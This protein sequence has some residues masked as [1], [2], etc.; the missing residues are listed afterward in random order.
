MY[1]FDQRAGSVR[2]MPFAL[3]KS[4]RIERQRFG[5]FRTMLALAQLINMPIS[6]SRSM[7]AS[8]SLLSLSFKALFSSFSASCFLAI[9]ASS[10]SNS[11][12][13]FLREVH[14]TKSPVLR[15]RRTK[16]RLVEYTSAIPSN[17]ETWTDTAGC[18]A[19]TRL[20]GAAVAK[21][22]AFVSKL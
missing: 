10:A 6:I 4:R 8:I 9:S 21:Q 3:Q 15:D 1:N 13:F 16:N 20:A 17:D 11:W 12:I 7:W 2:S 22:N 18:H 5:F 19:R 14:I